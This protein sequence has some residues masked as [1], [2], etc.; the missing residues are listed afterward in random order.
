M[1]WAVALTGLAAGPAPVMR[2]R[3]LTVEDGLAHDSVYAIA[4]DSLGFIWIG[5]EDGLNRFDGNT[6]D[7]FAPDQ[8]APGSLPE[9]DVSKLLVD[10]RGQMWVGTW[11]AGLALYDP[12]S[13]SFQRVR[14][15]PAGVAS[16]KDSRIQVLFE[17]AEHALWV[18]TYQSGLARL[19]SNEGAA[20]S[21]RHSPVDPRSL[22]S[23][24]VWSMTQCGD[25][26]LWVG[27]EAG[28][29]R[30]ARTSGSFSV[31]HHVPGRADTLPDDLVRALHCDQSGTLW[32]G[33]EAGFGRFDPVA[34]GFTPL[35]GHEPAHRVLATA[36]INTVS[37]TS[38]GSIWVGTNRSGLFRI[39]AAQSTLE[40]FVNDPNNPGSLANDDVRC[41]VED[42][43]GVLW[44]ATRGG[45]VDTFDLKPPKFLH[46]PYRPHDTGGLADR[47]VSAIIERHD[48][49]LWV[50]TFNGLNRWDETRGAFLHYVSTPSRSDSLPANV[51]RTLF[52]DRTGTLWVGTWRGG[53]SRYDDARDSFV[54]FRNT[55]GDP[56]SLVD[57]RL[58]TVFE[59]RD[60]TLWVATQ[61][62]LS[63][64]D[65]RSGTFTSFKTDPA[66][67]G[68][69]SDNAVWAMAQDR[70]GTLW[71]GTD[72]GGLSTLEAGSTRFQRHTFRPG[73]PASLRNN[74]V[75]SLHLGTDGRLWV[76]TAGGL[77]VL[78]QTG[79]QF[80]HLGAAE[81]VPATAIA[82]IVGDARG[83]LWLS[84]SHGITC[85]DPAVSTA[86][87]Y[88]T[89]DGL[90][91][92]QF[93][94]GSAFVCPDGR[95]YFGGINGYNVFH[96]DRVVQNPHRPPVVLRSFRRFDTPLSFGRP[97]FEQQ[98]ISLTYRDNFF[99]M[100]FAALDY[101]APER[102]RYSYILEGF[103]Q[104]WVDAGNRHSASYTNVDPGRYVF[105]VK[106]ANNDGVW[107][108][109][110][111]TLRIVISPP[112]WQTWW[113]RT[114]L[115]SVLLGAAVG[116]Y[117]LR[118]HRMELERQRLEALV[119]RRTAELVTKQEQLEKA[120]AKKN[121]FLG[122]AAHDLR[123]PLGLISAWTQL[124]VRNLES[125]RFT[126][127]RAAR[128][129]ARVLN[130]A[131]Q[132]N[133][134]VNELLDI[135][136]IESGKLSLELKPER[137]EPVLEECSHLYSQIAS[138]KGIQV[139]LEH[140][141]AAPAVL[142]DR[143]R[144]HEV[145]DNLLSNAIKYTFPGGRV[146]LRCE[147]AGAEVRVHVEDSG[148]GLTEKD[149]ESV[150]KG[151]S[152]L[153]ARP[154]GGEPSTGLGLAI[155][156]K[157]VEL[158]GG[159]VWVKSQK[160]VGSTFSFSLP[161][162]PGP[163][164]TGASAPPCPGPER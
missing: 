80:R 141:G 82:A 1:L 142:V 102:N 24:R 116:S 137:I 109:Q 25:G 60:G 77:D 118:V 73:D 71:F 16:L 57:D 129:L 5:T 156:K 14:E 98:E 75:R 103:D 72:S 143:S 20:A 157:I 112:F 47:R 153:S 69:L 85:L 33:T 147:S 150:F 96:P 36:S 51:V 56:T 8:G 110:G 151:F 108:D 59:D 131:E 126:S 94:G 101:T 121:E 161:V 158:H 62:G 149:L 48:G 117:R 100:E 66:D 91:G 31:F 10:S 35:A 12:T 159:R 28:L 115:A 130:A 95:M 113:F 22:S 89:S 90:Q 58:N 67:D 122:V 68:S 92:N 49:T 9:S 39:D 84:T 127:Q 54:T 19:E 107:N 2:F 17:D 136:S 18:G 55:P 81:G 128:E 15:N 65:R 7:R 120:D 134:L 119:A 63:R 135:S 61:G 13:E 53:L 111:A 152:K 3:H 124:T 105:R 99:T 106:A 23:D 34:H 139:L 144:I 74:R 30:F 83:R 146:S 87:S 132:M 123:N 163:D 86:H 93:L 133:R 148:Q 45:G 79:T 104:G 27:T 78:D 160:G 162:A 44:I 114:L 64:F 125:G 6:L 52:E 97:L 46:V 29:N 42:S 43:S 21:F 155:V 41:L 138:E 88:S 32:V 4:Q 37:Q 26:S 38:D 145:L 76:G 164:G 11:G 70:Q 154:T 140:D 40:H 50:G